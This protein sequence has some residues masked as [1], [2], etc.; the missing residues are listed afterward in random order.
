MF[1][2]LRIMTTE[3]KGPFFRNYII[4]SRDLPSAVEFAKRAFGDGSVG[5]VEPVDSASFLPPGTEYLE[6]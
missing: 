1:Y 4:Y 6:R 2:L 3:T 5:S